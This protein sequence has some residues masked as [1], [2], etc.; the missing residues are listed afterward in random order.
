[1][2]WSPTFIVLLIILTEKY[3]DYNEYINHILMVGE[4]EW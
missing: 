1:M 2:P 4:I 3:E